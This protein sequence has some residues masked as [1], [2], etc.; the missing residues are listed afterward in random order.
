VT[1][2]EGFQMLIGCILFGMGLLFLAVSICGALF[3]I[4]EFQDQYWKE[5][6]K[7]G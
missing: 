3:I 1:I 7:R 2:A 6:R 4:G 5:R